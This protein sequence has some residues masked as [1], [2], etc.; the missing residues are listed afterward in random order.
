[1]TLLNLF[2]DEIDYQYVWRIIIE[3]TCFCV[4]HLPLA[5]LVTTVSNSFCRLFPQKLFIC[6]PKKLIR[7]RRP[8][9]WGFFQTF[10]LPGLRNGLYSGKYLLKQRLIPTSPKTLATSH[11]SQRSRPVSTSKRIVCSLFSI[12]LHIYFLH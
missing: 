3:P 8:R 4:F 6:I 7:V 2:I 12:I 10:P 5:D 1:M 11:G 9:S